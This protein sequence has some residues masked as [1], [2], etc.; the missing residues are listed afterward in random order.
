M[1]LQEAIEAMESALE[2]VTD[3]QH[4]ALRL[5]YLEG[6]SIADVAQRMSRSEGAAH[7]LCNRGLGALREHLGDCSRFLTRLP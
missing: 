2:K 5:H 7:M 4:T 6:L 3:E 1:A